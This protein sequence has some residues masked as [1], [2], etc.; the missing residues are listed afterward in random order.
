[1]SR[2][3]PRGATLGAVAML[4]AGSLGGC[5]GKTHVASTTTPGAPPVVVRPISPS[6]TVVFEAQ[7]EQTE[8]P[9]ILR[10]ARI[11]QPVLVVARADRFW[12]VPIGTLLRLQHR[13][14]Q[15]CLH[16]VGCPNP[17]GSLANLLPGGDRAGYLRYPAS[18]TSAQDE[19]ED[20]AR[21]L[22]FGDD[23]IRNWMSPASGDP[24]STAEEYFFE[25][26]T[27]P[28][29]HPQLPPDLISLQYWFFYPFNYLPT[30]V[31][32]P[33]KL[34]TDPAGA[35][36]RNS[37]YHQG[38]FEHVEVLLDPNTLAPRYV[39]MARHSGEDL[40]YD[41]DS[42]DV[43]RVNLSDWLTHDLRQSTRSGTHPVIFSGFGGHASYAACG[44]Q[45]RPLS[46]RVAGVSI[47]VRIYDYTVCPN[48]PAADLKAPAG[49]VI[50]LG[51]LT[52]LVTLRPDSWAC[53]PGLFGDQVRS[54]DDKGVAAQTSRKQNGPEAPLRQAENKAHVCNGAQVPQ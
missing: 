35:T 24:S 1:V 14:R 12:P 26:H 47:G 34:G 48:P 2:W 31:R 13:G 4:L 42:P 38:D 45:A 20:E 32:S 53:W 17:L 3:I 15:V 43:T 18:L 46:A 16:I 33:E 22:G 9:A 40:A 6:P 41:W 44:Q 10:L 39:F 30:I 37:D 23:A 5:K 19:F 54:R 49:P 52:R 7:V 11:Y 50:R 28:R 25:S 8:T 27:T 51:P 29:A 21:A 36:E